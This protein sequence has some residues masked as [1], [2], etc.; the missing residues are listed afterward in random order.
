M[1]VEPSSPLPPPRAPI[2][3]D[4]PLALP[5]SPHQGVGSAIGVAPRHLDEHVQR[6]GGDE[7]SG[8][9]KGALGGGGGSGVQSDVSSVASDASFG[10]LDG[11]EEVED[12]E[13]GG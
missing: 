11:A 2:P 10:G 9:V 1:G 3:N 12:G 6:V 7:T 4:H 13:V 8:A 5:E